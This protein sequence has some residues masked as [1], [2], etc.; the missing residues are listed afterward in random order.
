MQLFLSV[1]DSYY[2]PPLSQMCT[3]VSSEKSDD[4]RLADYRNLQKGGRKGL[5]N[6]TLILRSHVTNMSSIGSWRIAATGRRLETQ[7]FRR[8][9]L[10][11]EILS[12]RTFI[13]VTPEIIRRTLM[14]LSFRLEK[15]ELRYKRTCKG[16]QM[17]TIG[18]R[19]CETIEC[20]ST[21]L[22]FGLVW[23]HALRYSWFASR[24]ALFTLS[25]VTL[26]GIRAH[27]LRLCRVS[28]NKPAWKGDIFVRAAPSLF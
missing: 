25:L 28:H 17:S 22:D 19:H 26:T 11:L 5:Y 7:S 18:Y 12:H 23:S 14:Y 9:L 16:R 15:H 8:R 6:T 27:T 3:R 10:N 20:I 24:A 21:N 13:A 2:F 4:R 1:K